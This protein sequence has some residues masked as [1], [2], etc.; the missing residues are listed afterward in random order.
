MISKLLM[1]EKGFFIECGALDGEI[2]SNTLFMEQNLGWE[3]VLI[4]A[5]PENF[6]K[7]KHKNRK[8]WAVPACLSTLS[9]PK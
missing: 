7:V 5:D 4:E 3:G 2:R 8:A 6:E 1:Q 9:T